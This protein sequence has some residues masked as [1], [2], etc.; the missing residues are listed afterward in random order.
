LTPCVHN[1]F[2]KIWYGRYPA[3]ALLAPFGVIFHVF[4]A[5]R[6][7]AYRYGLVPSYRAEIP[8]I[9]V[10]NVTV[11]GTGKTP[12]VI[13]L[14]NYLQHHGYKP[15]V[16]S[17]GYQGRAKNWPQQVRADSDPQM[18]G[19]EAIVLARRAKCPIAVGPKRADSVRALMDYADCDIIVSDD[20]LQHYGLERDVE[21]LVVDGVRRFGNGRCLPAGP[22]REPISRIK[23]VDLTVVNGI[24]GRGEFEMKTV[25]RYLYPLS[26][27]AAPVAIETLM[28][29]KVHAV[30]GIG[31]PERFFDLLRIK[32][33]RAEKHRFVDHHRFIPADFD[34]EDALPII[35]TEKDAVKC[36][37]F[38]LK[39]AWYLPIDIEMP[40]VFG[41]RL[42]STLKEAVNG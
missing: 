14:V 36:E 16:I 22:L 5:I 11:G 12:L 15:G 18:I 30:A 23:E 34:F 13:W 33:L 6:R 9:I 25:A 32:G 26:G 2:D 7:A 39:D 41:H 10:G 29:S 21:I 40:E 3:A 1:F 28:G 31:N 42:T 19:D 17:R 24:P 37:H 4:V 8:V 20:G 35:M 27:D 38:R